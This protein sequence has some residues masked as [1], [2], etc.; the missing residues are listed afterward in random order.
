[1]KALHLDADGWLPVVIG[2]PDWISTVTLYGT[3]DGWEVLEKKN[4]SLDEHKALAAGLAG[5]VQKIYAFWLE[6]RRKHI[7]SGTFPGVV[8]REPIGKARR[9][10]QTLRALQMARSRGLPAT[11]V[12]RAYVRSVIGAGTGSVL[13][14]SA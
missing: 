2:K 6:Q 10:C 3:E 11:V 1:M 9:G 12:A 14:P 7:A 8:R 4:L 13:E 5:T